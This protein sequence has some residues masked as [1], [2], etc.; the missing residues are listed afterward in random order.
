MPRPKLLLVGLS[1]VMFTMLSS[2]DRVGLPQAVESNEPVARHRA[3][4][5]RASC[6]FMD[7]P[8]SIYLSI[9]LSIGINVRFAAMMADVGD[10]LL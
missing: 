3:L 7:R 6:Q 2:T 5:P 1:I 8:Y 9:Y 4:W 10:G